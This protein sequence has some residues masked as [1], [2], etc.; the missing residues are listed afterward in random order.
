MKNALA[1]IRRVVT[2]DDAK[3]KSRIVEDAPAA[4]FDTRAIGQIY[5]RTTS[6]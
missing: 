4:R 2:A 1:P 5:D 3:G 6:P